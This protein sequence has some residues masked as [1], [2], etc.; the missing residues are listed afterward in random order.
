MATFAPVQHLAERSLIFLRSLVYRFPLPIMVLTIHASGGWR[1]CTVRKYPPWLPWP[2]SCLSLSP[3]SPQPCWCSS[4]FTHSP[5]SPGPE[6]L[7]II[8][9]FRNLI[10]VV[11]KGNLHYRIM[12]RTF[13]SINW[14]MII[15][16][17]QLR[18]QKLM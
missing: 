5:C 17:L 9:T 3:P 14:T 1:R 2:C 12:Q 7:P 6:I 16:N 8:G 15:L 11:G 10:P 4:P 13:S 18:M